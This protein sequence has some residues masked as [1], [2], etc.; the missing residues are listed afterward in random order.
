MEE[1]SKGNLLDKWQ[2][3]N[4]FSSL[5]RKGIHFLPCQ[6]TETCTF[7]LSGGFLRNSKKNKQVPELGEKNCQKPWTFLSLF[8]YILREVAKEK[9]CKTNRR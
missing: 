9:N 1:N 7:I 5:P 2:V 4:F 3:F 8:Y 6:S